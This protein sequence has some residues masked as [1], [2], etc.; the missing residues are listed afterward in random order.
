MAENNTKGS[1]SMR[2]K[3][4]KQ[5]LM[6][7]IVVVSGMLPF[8]SGSV[9]KT[10]IIN[11]ESFYPEGPFVIYGDL[12]YVE[13]SKD[14]VMKYSKKTKENTV[15]FE[16]KGCGP[17]SLVYHKG[18]TV[19][20]CY[21]SSSLVFIDKEG[22]KRNEIKTD[23]K[24]RE[25]NGPNDFAIHP[26]GTL[27]FSASGIFDVA[28][29]A[30]G[31]IYYLKDAVPVMLCDNLHYANGLAFSA[32]GNTLYVN[33]H[34]AGKITSFH[35]KKT[36]KEDG[37]LQW[38][39]ED[40]TL[41]YQFDEFKK[42]EY[43]GPDGLK[44]DSEGNLWAALYGAGK[45]IRLNPKE[46]ITNR[47]ILQISID[48]KYVTNLFLKEDENSIYTSVAEDAFQAPYPGKILRLELDHLP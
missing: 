10:E 1:K 47:A 31:R 14:R 48:E 11:A 39:A 8:C 17:A 12:F 35:L 7:V 19:V 38:N 25:L 34:L 46:K 43:I 15:F 40:R 4:R 21:D 36:Q 22:K 33:E 20:S 32:G 30:S 6:W 27:F 42:G 16:Q 24:G 45:I 23:S 5:F 18:M 3:I 29:K 26:N 41:F 28:A 9:K 13:Y 44:I 2:I 37:G